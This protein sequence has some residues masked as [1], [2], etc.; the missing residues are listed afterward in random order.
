MKKILL[1]ALTVLLV[2]PVMSQDV[3]SELQIRLKGVDK[4]LEK[5]LETWNAAGFA[6][7]VVERNNVLYANGFGYRDYENKIP[8]TANT[9]FAIGS[10]SKSFT[11]SLLGILRDEDKLSFDD[12]P[13][14][15][16]PEL[17]FFNKELENS[18]NI[19]DMMSHRTGLPRHDLSWYLFPTDSKDS[20]IQR[21]EFM[22]PFTGVR[23]RWYYNNFMYLAQGV[24]AERITGNSWEENVRQKIFVPLNMT[25]SNLSI[26]E[27]EK[28]EEPALGYEVDGEGKI[29]KMD[30]YKIA[31]MSPAGSI[32]SS[33][34]EMANWLITWING[35][36]FNGDEILPANF[37]QEAAS[38]QMVIGGG[39]P[40]KEHP[41]LHMSNYGYGWMMSSYRGHYRVQ[42]GGNINGFSA[43][44]CFLPS[45][46]I[47]IVVLTNQDGSS[48]P[49][50]VRNILIDRVLDLPYIDWNKELKD[51]RDKAIKDQKEASVESASNKES[52]TR[53]SHYLIDYTGIYSHPGYGEFTIS[54]EGDSL[55]ANFPLNKLLLR[56]YHYDV[57]EPL[58]VEETGIDTTGFLGGGILFNF[59]TGIS[60]KISGLKIKIE[61]AL[62]PVEFNRTP[63]KAEVSIETLKK[64]AGE[65]D[66]A[67]TT[68]KVYLKEESDLYLF[69]PGQPEYELY[70]TGLNKFSIKILDGYDVEFVE[71]NDEITAILF[72]QPNGTFKAARK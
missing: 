38:S 49:S 45:D 68:A 18:I 51:R 64:Y 39:Y 33:A 60:G 62:D 17:K 23:E 40:G 19:K 10:C 7:A 46:S 55:Y 21:I 27:L 14:K 35:G 70:P 8:A 24:I 29:Q 1:I 61:T 36:K 59:I 52:G 6:V 50:V 2:S 58:E 56:H 16:I 42:H 54:V 47:G 5:I 71:E 41:D 63:E 66:L 65:Y 20:L 11:T 48:I 4:E 26:R 13:G 12:A 72:I 9:L 15:Y 30:Y 53:H 32:N 34:N 69:V 22:E 25:T 43:S 37:V 3:K 57:F 28:S 44:S 31:G 67:G